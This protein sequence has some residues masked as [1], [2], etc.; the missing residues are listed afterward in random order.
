MELEI[1]YNK[2]E[3]KGLDSAIMVLHDTMYFVYKEKLYEYYG[4]VYNTD[5]YYYAFVNY[6]RENDANADITIIE[7]DLYIA[8]K[9]PRGGLKM[10]PATKTFNHYREMRQ[11]KIYE[12]CIRLS[13]GSYV[14]K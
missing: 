9:Y 6:L 8:L 5:E 1:E 7:H 4:L 11:K 14:L 2:Y 12:E 3:V 10:T 13:P